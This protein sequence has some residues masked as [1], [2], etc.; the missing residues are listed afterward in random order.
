MASLTWPPRCEEQG[1]KNEGD[2]FLLLTRVAFSKGFQIL[3]PPYSPTLESWSLRTLQL[4]LEG[5]L[6]YHVHAFETDEETEAQGLCM[7]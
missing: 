3:P 5:T 7:F 6:A 1:K 2:P 4:H